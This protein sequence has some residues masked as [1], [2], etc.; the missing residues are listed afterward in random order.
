MPA[1]QASRAM[2]MQYE[3]RLT[4]WMHRMNEGLSGYNS[5]YFSYILEMYGV[6]VLVMLLVVCTVH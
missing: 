1:A 2:F 4:Y 3:Y 5:V 6:E